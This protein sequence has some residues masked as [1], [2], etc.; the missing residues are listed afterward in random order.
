MVEEAEISEEGTYYIVSVKCHEAVAFDG[1]IME[2][3]NHTVWLGESDR[4]AQCTSDKNWAE[5][6]DNP[7]T[8]EEMSQ[9]DGKPWYHKFKVGTSKVFKV[10][11]VKYKDKVE[12]IE[13]GEAKK[14]KKHD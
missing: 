9:Y 6:F 2:V 1:G 14:E 13:L 11:E 8:I 5:Q 3:D 4:Y 7:P 10:H 12:T